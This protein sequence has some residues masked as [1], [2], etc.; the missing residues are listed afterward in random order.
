MSHC[1]ILGDVNFDHLV[2]IVSTNFLSFKI[3]KK[4]LV[5]TVFEPT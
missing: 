5:R 4:S 3:S 2:R 1:P